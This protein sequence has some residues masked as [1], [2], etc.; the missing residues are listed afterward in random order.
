MADWDDVTVLRKR[1]EVPRAAKNQTVLNEARR[2]GAV[3]ATERKYTAASNKRGADN[4]QRLAKIDNDEDIPKVETVKLSVG[5]AIQKGRQDKGLTQ[6]DLGQRINEKANVIN[7]YEAGR[8]KWMGLHA[9]AD[10]RCI[11]VRLMDGL[12]L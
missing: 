9:Y 8:G 2:V 4:H 10:A 3:V 12:W 7:D 6:K 11:D 5:R 1:Q